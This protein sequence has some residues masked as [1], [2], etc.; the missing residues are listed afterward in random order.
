ML[1]ILIKLHSFPRHLHWPCETTLVIIIIIIHKLY[2]HLCVF[3]TEQ[4]TVPLQYDIRKLRQLVVTTINKNYARLS[5]LIE[6]SLQEV[7]NEFF[8]VQL[9]T[10]SVRS[11]P[12]SEKLLKE[13]TSGME[14]IDNQSDMEKRCKKF[15]K[16]CQKM[17]GTFLL[18]SQ[19][20]K[21][22]WI[23]ATKQEMGISLSLDL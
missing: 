20:F 1:W 8:Q 15:L 22:E 6:T 7:T 10:E 11:K 21:C 14:W 3:I 16:V 5:N 9:I 19:N 4:Q 18:V 13:F 17:G 23:E 2:N 12:T